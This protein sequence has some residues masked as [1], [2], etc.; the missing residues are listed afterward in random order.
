M[1][2]GL[3]ELNIQ[4]ADFKKATQ[5]PFL[6]QAG[7]GTLDSETLTKW[8]RQ[9]YLYAFVGYIKVRLPLHHKLMAVRISP[10]FSD[11]PTFFSTHIRRILQSK[12]VVLGNPS[13]LIQ[14]IE[15]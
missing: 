10:A 14:S 6:V 11:P 5:H 4:E 12:G 15:R 8:C 13:S 1:V 2:D 3:D 7:N 9:D